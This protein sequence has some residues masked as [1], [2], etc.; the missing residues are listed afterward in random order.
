MKSLVLIFLAAAI[1]R[2]WIIT[3]SYKEQISLRIE[4]STPVNSIHR[5]IESCYRAD[6]GVDPYSSDIFHESPLHLVFYQFLITNF[7]DY[8]PFV[9]IFVDLL[10]A[11]LLFNMAKNYIFYL[12]IEQEL[13]GDEYMYTDKE[14]VLNGYDYISTPKYVLIAYL[15]NPYVIA[16]CVGCTTATFLNLSYAIFLF[17]ISYGS[18]LF[19]VVALVLCSTQALY[20]IVLISPLY[21]SI[22]KFNGSKLAFISLVSFLICLATFFAVCNIINDGWEFIDKSYGF[23]L[24]VT[25]QQPNIGVYWYFFME[26]FEHFRQLFLYSYQINVSLLYCVPLTIKF[27]KDPVLLAFTFITLTAIFKSYPGIGDF[28]FTLAVLPCWKYMYNCMQQIFVSGVAIFI[29]TALGP[30]LWDLWI[31][32]GT[33]NANFYFGT[34]LAFVT[35]FIF[36]LTDVAFA[37]SKKEYLL[38]FGSIRKINGKNAK[39]VL[40]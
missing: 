18:I 6:L 11:L 31:F 38:R 28:A 21:L 20:P 2:C 23:I 17:G 15:F 27:R 10:I 13:K 5:V 14:L 35:A 37:Y 33:A 26:M 8:L 36:I 12:Y 4:V 3:S 34:T 39:L 16:N 29:T 25:D 30:I 1:I 19:P 32:M 40:E 9:F 7:G 24:G 22:A